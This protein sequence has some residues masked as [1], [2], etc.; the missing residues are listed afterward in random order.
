MK[1]EF[2]MLFKIP[3]ITQQEH[4]AGVKDRTKDG[5]KSPVAYIYDTP[6]I[7][8][9]RAL[10]RSHLAQHRPAEPL[11][12]PIELDVR[13]Y[14]EITD[15]NH[16]DGDFKTTKPDCSN[17]IKLLEDEMTRVGFWKDDAQVAILFEYK[18]WKEHVEGVGIT[19][20]QIGRN[21]EE[22]FG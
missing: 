8:D 1:I 22:V 20:K 4:R 2:S 7:K 16:A 15:G 21:I 19:V 6:E 10:F 11:Q 13:W 12:G 17:L 3:S 9:A 5:K 18:I 14:Y